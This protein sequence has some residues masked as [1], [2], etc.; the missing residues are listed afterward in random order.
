MLQIWTLGFVIHFHEIN[1][2]FHLEFWWF[3]VVIIITFYAEVYIYLLRALNVVNYSKE[4][5]AVES[6]AF[7]VI[8]SITVWVSS[9]QLPQT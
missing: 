2:I 8:M 4:I 1:F 6:S 9:E 7:P 5:A 3:L